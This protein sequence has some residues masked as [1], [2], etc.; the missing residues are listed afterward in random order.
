VLLICFTKKSRNN[1]LEEGFYCRGKKFTLFRVK[2]IGRENKQIKNFELVR[3]GRVENEEI[4]CGTKWNPNTRSTFSCC[5]IKE[6]LTQRPKSFTAVL[7]SLSVPFVIAQKC[8]A[9]EKF[10]L[11][12]TR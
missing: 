7:R 8:T 6:T 1:A 11:L 3:C 4:L 5:A 2:L 9:P 10:L 12:K